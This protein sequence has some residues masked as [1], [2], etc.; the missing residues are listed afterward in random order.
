MNFVL[1]FL[2]QL[3]YSLSDLGKKIVLQRVHF[4]WHLLWNTPFLALSIAAIAGFAL[5]MFVL[6]RYELSKTIITLGVLAVLI[7]TALGLFVLHE[8]LSAM[9]LVGV[10]FAL[11]A[12]VLLQV[13]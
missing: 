4:G 5:Q 12:I 8:R 7:Q 10:I 11:A 1:L 6:S 2:A 3:I 13:K 9:N